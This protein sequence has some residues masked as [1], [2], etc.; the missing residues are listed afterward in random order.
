[1]LSRQTAQWWPFASL[2]CDDTTRPRLCY[3]YQTPRGEGPNEFPITS[4]L[5]SKRCPYVRVLVIWATYES[6][7]KSQG[8]S[9]TQLVEQ[10]PLGLRSPPEAE[11]IISVNTQ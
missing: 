7:P 2:G 9:L 3:R 6:L 11:G 1:M 5:T 4:V 8:N 10:G